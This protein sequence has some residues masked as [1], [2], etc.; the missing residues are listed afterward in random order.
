MFQKDG[1]KTGRRIAVGY[2][3]CRKYAQ[4][5]YCDLT[6]GEP[7]TVS[8]VA[9]TEQYNIPAVLCKRAGVG[10]WY[11]GKE[12][13]NFA[14]QQEAG[15]ILVEDL[16]TLADRGEEVMVEGNAYDPVAL[17]T[18]FVKRSLVLLGMHVPMAKIEA[19]M[20][21]VEDLTPR[22]VDV[23]LRVAGG[24]SLEKANVSFQNHLESFYAYTLHQNK[25]LY[26]NDVVVYEYNSVLKMMCLSCNEH[27]TPKVVLI[28]QQE[29]EQMLR[30]VW[31]TEEETCKSQKEDLDE[32]FDGIIK[33]SLADRQVST[34]FLIGDG[35]KEDWARESLRTL[36]RGR[37]VFQGN[38]LYSKGACYGML[39]RLSPSE[40]WKQYV[41]LG[42]DK[43]KS[44]VGMRALRN[45]Q[46]AY[47]AVLDA[48]SS[49][50]ET[51][52]D[53]EVIL[54]SGDTVEFIITPLTGGKVMD[55]KVQLTGIP[56]R[57]R[58]ATRLSVHLEMT[59]VNQAN[60]TI[61]DLGFGEL[62]P[63]SGK[64]WSST[65]TI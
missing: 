42:E 23:L 2:D 61:E 57:P 63:S 3:L 38:N 65:I 27:T 24:L 43:L 12:A 45:G 34:V 18:L 51:S 64:A 54:E 7:E 59:S 58:A 33:E 5:S 56:Q 10:Q 39:E 8:A 29:Y 32:L 15:G 41:Y 49:W 44:N 53:Y 30:R 52:A 37:R 62:F 60:V 25:E 19:I 11:Y 26:Q 6:E 16:L 20:F 17:L 48:G 36:C 1:K 9:G 55:R 14:K 35:F 47:F 22:M 40:K 13:L 28:G 4:I 21:T 31:S 46:E 50:Y